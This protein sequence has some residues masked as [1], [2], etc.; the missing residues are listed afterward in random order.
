MT[1]RAAIA[2]PAPVPTPLDYAVPSPSALPAAGV[3]VR[4]PLGKRS[5]IGISL[6]PAPAPTDGET[7]ACRPIE[8][9]L[10]PQPV[11][12]AATLELAR[13]CADYY[14]HPLGQV[15]ATALPGLLR[16]GR[17][18]GEDA[19]CLGLSAA[20]RQAT[21]GP[22]AAALSALLETL[23]AQPQRRADLPPK[24]A[25]AVP[26]ALAH[27]WLEPCSPNLPPPGTD[28][29]PPLPSAEQAAAWQILQPALSAGFSVHLIDGVTGSGKTE[30]YLRLAAETL[31]A[32]RQV[33]ILT[34][35]IGLTPQLVERCRARFGNAVQAYHS[36][37]G[38]VER[39]RS[40]LAA[41]EA[42][43]QIFVGTRSAI[44]LPLAAPGLIIVDEEHDAAYKQQ[45]GLRYSARDL[46]AVR[47]RLEG[48]P[49][50]LGSAT[51]ALETLHNV[52]RGRY[53][54]LPLR[55]RVSGAPPPQVQLL[56]LRGRPLR[57]GLSEVLLEAVDRELE[58]GGQALL[59]INRRGYAPALLCHLCGWTAPCPRCD[60]RLTAHRGGRLLLC[61]HC[62]HRQAPPT[63]CPDCGAAQWLPVGEG[64]QRIEEALARRF[65]GRRIERVDSD[66]RRSA[67]SL[68]R[69]FE[70]VHAGR[71]DLLVGTQMLA[72]GHDF[73]GLGLAGL[74]DVDAALYQSDFRALERL[75]QLLTQVAG[76]V[77]RGARAGTVLL[78][79]HTPDHPLLR[80]LLAEGYPALAAA[81]LE[82]RRSHRLPPFS[83]LALLRAEAATEGAALGFLGRV[84]GAFDHPGVERLGPVPAPM[85]RRAGLWRGQLLLR[86]G[87]RRPLQAAL[88]A[89]LPTLRRERARGL[90]WS[91]DVDPYDLY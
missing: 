88:R 21:P 50:V 34:P 46:A 37:M 19:P 75:G 10:D 31:A 47:A 41:L 11:F 24:L 65:P 44:F 33:L 48:L 76:R 30:L 27:G 29:A 53:R 5:V 22:R 4:V 89:A 79:T 45:D 63:A 32:G 61:H 85:E 49:L 12:Q 81:L 23:R 40:W 26:R 90:R 55:R 43:P 74:V 84:G 38:E 80:K 54:T 36:G 3:R 56:D 20:G 8:A 9:V 1:S 42:R 68:A 72:K 71:I 62:G 59:F 64:T 17:Q 18:P 77:G 13:W 52:D 57:D 39:A 86:A 87:D 60:A 7:P 15:L 58:S 67:R 83:H 35:E 70:D 78:Q 73:H 69:L 6:G 16:A 51:P 28:A 2:V 66:R 25:A 91:L 82:E 14:Q